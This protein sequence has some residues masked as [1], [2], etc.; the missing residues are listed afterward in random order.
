MERK[1]CFIGCEK[2]AEYVIWDGKEPAYDHE[3]ESCIDHIGQLLSDS[4]VPNR[5][6]PI[7]W[8]V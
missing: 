5:V 7:E 8:G 6:Y 4:V 1:C 3:T 2:D